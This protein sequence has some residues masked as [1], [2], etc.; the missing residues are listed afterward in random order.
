MNLNTVLFKRSSLLILTMCAISLLSL[1]AGCGITSDDDGGTEDFV[2]PKGFGD[3]EE[4]PEG[5]PLILPAGITLESHIYVLN[6]F[7]ETDCEG[8]HLEGPRGRETLVPLCL[9]F[10]NNTDGPIN[11]ELPPGLI[12]VSENIKAQNGILI[13]GLT[14]EVPSDQYIVSPIR[15]YC[16]NDTR[17]IPGFGEEFKYKL[18]P[19]TQYQPMLDLF[20][21]LKTKKIISEIELENQLMTPKIQIMVWD[22]THSTTLSEYSQALYNELPNK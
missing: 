11:V 21:K 20:D 16:L 3:S 5:A 15:A 14:I 8:S 4:E 9:I 6:Y 18:G 22:L 1:S 7:D 2:P 17:S 10:R 13:E 19:V 12:F